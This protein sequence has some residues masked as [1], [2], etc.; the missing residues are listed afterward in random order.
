MMMFLLQLLEKIGFIKI[1][2][3]KIIQLEVQ[4]IQERINR[5]DEAVEKT[6]ASDNAL[7]D[8]IDALQKQMSRNLDARVMARKMK[9]AYSAP[10]EV[11]NA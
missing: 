6:N 1:D 10:L 7:L 5:I 4:Q 8:Q 2:G 9:K 11:G 3:V